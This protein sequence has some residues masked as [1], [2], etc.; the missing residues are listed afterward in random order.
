MRTLFEICEDIK[1]G[2][3]A[4][5]EEIRCALLVYNFMFNLEHRQYLEILEKDEVMNK[6]NRD[7]KRK[8]SFDMYKN[9]LNKA[10]DEYLG[11][12]KNVNIVWKLIINR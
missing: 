7:L 6:F 12:V 9:A 4:D 8:Y 2:K 10:P 11:I 5:Y 1:D 3:K